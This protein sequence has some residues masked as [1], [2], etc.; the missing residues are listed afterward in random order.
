MLSC[1]RLHTVTQPTHA[2]ANVA[3]R[4]VRGIPRAPAAPVRPIAASQTG[5]QP[6]ND[7]Q[8]VCRCPYGQMCYRVARLGDISPIGLLFK[9][10]NGSGLRRLFTTGLYLGLFSS[11]LLLRLGTFGNKYLGYFSHSVATLC[12]K[13][14]ASNLFT[15]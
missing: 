13:N 5:S 3:I 10:V 7:V 4:I 8:L 15:S 12:R 9:A 1:Y 14:L 11:A 6:S 2:P